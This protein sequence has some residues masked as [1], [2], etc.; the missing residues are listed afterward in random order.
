MKETPAPAPSRRGET[1]TP[2]PVAGGDWP[3]KIEQVLARR[4]PYGAWLAS[5]E[6][7]LGDL[8]ARLEE[9]A[10]QKREMTGDAALWP[11]LE[12]A[13]FDGL[14]RR[15]AEQ[16]R[17]L[18]ELGRRFRRETLNVAVVGMVNQGK[19]FLLR[20]LSG[21][22]PTVIPDRGSKHSQHDPLT[23]ARSTI[24]HESGAKI[25]GRVFFYTEAELLEILNSYR[26]GLLAVGGPGAGPALASPYTG[27]ADFVQRPAPGASQAANMPARYNAL[28]EQLQK[29]RQTLAASGQL[30]GRGPLN[31]LAEDQIVNYVTQ[32]VGR[33]DGGGTHL[34]LLVKEVQIACEFPY[35]RVGKIALIDLPGL[36]EATLGGPERLWRTLRLDADVALFVWR[37]MKGNLVEGND[38]ISLY[39]TCYQ[40]MKDT[41]PLHEWSF[42][43]LNHDRTVN[44]HLE[45]CEGTLKK[46]R[47]KESLFKF[48][49]V[50]ICDCSSPGEVREEILRPVLAHLAQHVGELDRRVAASCADGINALTRDAAAML[51]QVS[52]SFGGSGDDWDEREFG[53]LFNERWDEL[54]LGL[55][56]LVL[57]LKGRADEPDETF[58]RRV[59]S[60]LNECAEVHRSLKPQE[61]QAEIDRETS[62]DLVFI[63]RMI[64][65]RAEISSRLRALDSALD[66][67]LAAV[68]ERVASVFGTRGGFGELDGQSGLEL[69]RDRLKPHSPS[70]RQA[71]DNLID[72]RMSA[73]GLIGYK[74]RTK[75][76]ALEPRRSPQ[77][78]LPANHGGPGV[79]AAVAEMVPEV[80]AG[81]PGLT[82]SVR[83][84][85]VIRVVASTL[86][87]VAD[88]GDGGGADIHRNVGALISHTLD[89]IGKALGEDYSRPN[90]VAYAIV[91]D[92]V[93]SVVHA[94]GA[95]DEW[96]NVY[97][98]LRESVW[99]SD[100]EQQRR[101]Q[102]LR[103]GLRAS[104]Q[105]ALGLMQDGPPTL[106]AG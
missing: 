83:P 24:I 14:A 98:S 5:A 79:A 10:G 86:A 11:H 12:R 30:V 58:T 68:K 71:L 76:Q 6:K 15:A 61:G 59:G 93:D 100:Y 104:M 28:V 84:E 36:G 89:E 92:F 102:V 46:I 67:P 85:R 78:S 35:D 74:V 95:E 34:Y 39:D 4:K 20:T 41:L 3:E 103:E 99:L 73:R 88:R 81:V 63:N 37:P 40:A 47:E 90:Q 51:R 64:R 9:S 23:G 27:V 87:G 32:N 38:F 91:A 69:L 66:Q 94:E 26:A 55:N 72:F 22:P 57:E 80:S 42:L 97:R 54:R 18:D 49:S 7:Y 106:P 48:F 13:D 16:R 21:L 2:P 29:Y 101:Q 105:R 8:Q 19:S 43:V 52:D 44:G 1:N 77:E 82:V 17:F 75:L 56:N 65:A 33:R 60:A 53:R 96:R 45:F 62:F 50:K 31:G 25:T 70:L